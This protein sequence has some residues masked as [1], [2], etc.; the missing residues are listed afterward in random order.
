MMFLFIMTGVKPVESAWH[1]ALKK[2]FRR[3]KTANRSYQK[4]INVSV[5]VSAKSIALILQ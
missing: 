3:I 5:V 2:L 1:F 4:K